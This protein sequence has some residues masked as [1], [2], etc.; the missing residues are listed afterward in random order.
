MENN[1]K[2]AVVDCHFEDS[3]ILT[4]S[5]SPNRVLHDIISHNV[6]ENGILEIDGPELSARTNL[7][8]VADDVLAQIA[9]EVDLSPSLLKVARKDKNQGDG[10]NAQT[11]RI[12]P[13]I[14]NEQQLTHKIL[15]HEFVV[16]M[17]SAK[18]SSKQRLALWDDIYHIK[19]NINGTWLVRGDFN[20]VLNVKEKI[21]GLP[22]SNAD[23]EDFDCCIS[24]C[25]LVETRFK[26]SHFIWWNERSDNDC[27]FK[28]LDRIIFNQ[29]MQKLF[30]HM[31]VEHLPLIGSDH[32]P[33]FLT[34]EERRSQYRKPFRFL[35]LW[36]NHAFF[37]E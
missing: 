17:V 14:N 12:Q 35:K 9:K 28:R 22:I 3:Q 31:D 34:G 8:E 2:L 10:E 15:P 18:C 11:I 5:E 6:D 25:D 29:Q 16:T 26:E 1:E 19:E 23:H 37:H 20:V 4:I 13:K 33:M 30:K 27:I 24:T 7:E 32:S 36:T 21:R